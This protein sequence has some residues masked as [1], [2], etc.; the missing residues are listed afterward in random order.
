MESLIRQSDEVDKRRFGDVLD[1]L[2]ASRGSSGFALV[3]ISDDCEL[4]RQ[5]TAVVHELGL[6]I[7]NARDL[8]SWL[9]LVYE[10]Q[11]HYT[12][13]DMHMLAGN[14]PDGELC[15]HLLDHAHRLIVALHRRDRVAAEVIA[16]ADV[17]EV[18]FK[19]ADPEEVWLRISRVLREVPDASVPVTEAAPAELAASSERSTRPRPRIGCRILD[20]ALCALQD[21]E[22]GEILQL[23][24]AECRAL[25]I[26][27]EHRGATVSR[28]MFSRHVFGEDW[29]PRSRRL[30]AL[31]SRLRRKLG[32]HCTDHEEIRTDFGRGYRLDS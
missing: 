6:E 17:A 14:P 9:K 2:E 19:P 12:L 8:V 10:L 5:V 24:S 32:C 18:V 11:P 29:D 22:T 20:V 13:I 28:E 21:I 1:P 3:T 15:Q 30:D 23:S 4:V 31:M 25:S 7:A 26:L 16:C 27:C